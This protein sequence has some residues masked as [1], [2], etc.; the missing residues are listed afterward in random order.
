MIA[1]ITQNYFRRKITLAIDF[2]W[3][4]GERE[5]RVLGE[6]RKEEETVSMN[7]KKISFIFVDK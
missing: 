4:E 7:K 2:E 5:A 1:R 6:E 3:R